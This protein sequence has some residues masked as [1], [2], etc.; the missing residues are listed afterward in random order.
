M[1]FVVGFNVGSCG[2]C[3]TCGQLD[4][5]SWWMV[6]VEERSNNRK[7]SEAETESNDMSRCNK[8]GQGRRGGLGW[9]RD[10]D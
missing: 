4:D 6:R 8:I 9:V 2:S 3:F 10:W 5:W 1:L 7:S